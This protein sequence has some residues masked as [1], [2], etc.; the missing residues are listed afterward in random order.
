[1][2]EFRRYEKEAREN[3]RGLRG[4]SGQVLGGNQL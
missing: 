1:M 3:E 4:T 2:E